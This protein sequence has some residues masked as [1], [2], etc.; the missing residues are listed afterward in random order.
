MTIGSILLGLALLGLVGLF[1]VRP[2]FK[3]DPRRKGKPQLT[4][5]QALRLQKEAILTEIKSLDFDFNTG[6][7]PESEYEQ[8]RSQLMAEATDILK[9]LDALD[10]PT[11]PTELDVEPQEIAPERDIETDIEKAVAGLRK[12]P[13]GETLLVAEAT[14]VG[15]KNGTT[16]FCPQCGRPTDPGDKFCANCGHKLLIPQHA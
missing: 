13:V 7:F 8:R 11:A 16:N 14:P 5:R 6:K 10:M 2:L 9:E 15:E 12:K 3:P 1:I 4:E